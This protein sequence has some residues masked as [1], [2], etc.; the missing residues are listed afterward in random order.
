[1]ITVH[2]KCILSGEHTVLI[3]G[4]AI[5]VP[6]HAFKM[7]FEMNEA[8]DV[9]VYFN[10]ACV[11]ES[12]FNLLMHKIF[13]DYFPVRLN[14]ASN[15]PQGA[16]LGSSAAFCVGIAR[17]LEKRGIVKEG[18]V[19]EWARHCEDLFHGK[20]SGVD[21]A[22]VMADGPILF[23]MKNGSNP[24]SPVWQPHL[25]LSSSG[26]SSMTHLSVS[27]V[28]AYRNAHPNVDMDV[29]MQVASTMISNALISKNQEN[30]FNL[31][32][33]GLEKANECFKRWGLISEFLQKHQETLLSHGAIT[34][35]P[36]GSG[37]GGYVLS[38]WNSPPPNHLK[39]IE[40]KL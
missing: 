7:S 36:T 16:G 30:R 14:I 37:E 34:S 40:V 35:K 27:K 32:K 15:I 9:A 18:D 23:N 20:S 26:Q 22:G 24:I 33:Q 4:D 5:V 8:A 1:M 21:I 25:Y 6:L 17:L 39:L 12:K 29:E 10:G 31:L 38:L 28:E 3:G 19:F 11:E 13:K 2:S